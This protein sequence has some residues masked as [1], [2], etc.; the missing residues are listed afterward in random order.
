MHKTLIWK[1]MISSVPIIML[2]LSRHQIAIVRLRNNISK[3]DKRI[4]HNVIINLW[5]L[6][7][8][9]PSFRETS[10]DDFPYAAQT[11]QGLFSRWIINDMAYTIS[12]NCCEVCLYKE[13][14]IFIN[15]DGNRLQN[16]LAN[17]LTQ[18]RSDW[19]TNFIASK[20]SICHEYHIYM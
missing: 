20:K 17:R 16:Y 18:T 5:T 1:P 9:L 3:Y 12:T 2:L 7:Y 19:L 6:S 8:N 11:N 4:V 15:M 10:S 14:Q 13:V